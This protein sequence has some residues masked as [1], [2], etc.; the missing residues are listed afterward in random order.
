MEAEKDLSCTGVA[1]TAPRIR[2]PP[3]KGAMKVPKE[4]KAWA[5]LSRLA[6]VA[7]GPRLVTYGFAETW[8]P[9]MPAARI[10]RAVRKRGKDAVA[11]AG[12]KSRA[13]MAMMIRPMTMVCL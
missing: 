11:A 10:T 8:R 4:L 1:W 2:A 7:W 3:K 5:R 6:A 9:V 12:R 13:P